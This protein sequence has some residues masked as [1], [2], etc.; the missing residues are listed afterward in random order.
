MLQANGLTNAALI[1]GEPQ[2]THDDQDR[3]EI[4]AEI[5]TN[6][7]K[8]IEA[9]KSNRT[10]IESGKSSHFSVNSIESNLRRR[11][12]NPLETAEL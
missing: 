4:K 12:T 2:M 7:L 5:E 6:N 10:S 3:P 1:N 11:I 8:D 9:N